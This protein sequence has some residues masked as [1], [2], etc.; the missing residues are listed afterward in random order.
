MNDTTLVIVATSVGLVALALGAW[1][2]LHPRARRNRL[3]GLVLLLVG[4][5]A[6]AGAFV[7]PADLNS[8][9]GDAA[10]PTAP[11]LITTPESP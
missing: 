11:Q 1:A 4:C 3:A 5:L 2:V 7:T 10:E 6:L 8:D 9:D